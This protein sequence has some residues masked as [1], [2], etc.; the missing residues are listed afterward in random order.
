MVGFIYMG[1]CKVENKLENPR[2]WGVFWQFEASSGPKWQ[3]I[4]NT[5]LITV[6]NIDSACSSALETAS[7]D[8]IDT[9]NKAFDAV[10]YRL[11]R[12]VQWW[13]ALRDFLP[14]DGDVGMAR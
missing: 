5:Y 10:F 6:W 11:A 13:N 8:K 1:S 9:F 14:T 4:Y 12:P 3:R 2:F 7:N